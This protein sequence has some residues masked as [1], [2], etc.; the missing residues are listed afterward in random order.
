[1]SALQNHHGKTSMMRMSLAI[2]LGTGVVLSLSGAAAIFLK[3]PDASV[4][5]NAGVGLMSI[6][7][8]AKAAQSNWERPTENI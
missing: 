2:S 6:G 4:L 1:M 5:V 7:S 8:I 3:I